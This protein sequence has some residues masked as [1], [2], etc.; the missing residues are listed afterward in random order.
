MADDKRR[1]FVVSTVLD[2]VA[3][4][5][6][7]DQL[8]MQLASDADG[9]MRAFLD[10][11][12]TMVFQATVTGG[13]IKSSNVVSFDTA[14]TGQVVLTK[15]KAGALTLADIPA[16]VAV[17]SMSHS[18]VSAL[19]HQLLNIYGPLLSKDGEDAKLKGLVAELEAGLGKKLRLTGG[20]GGGKDSAGAGGDPGDAPLVGI[21]HPLDEFKLWGEVAFAKDATQALKKCANEVYRAFE[22][23]KQRF[24][25]LDELPDEDVLELV[26]T[27]SDC[28]DAAWHLPG[29]SGASGKAAFPQRRMEHL[30]KIIG[31]SLVGHVQHKLRRVSVWTDQFKAVEGLLRFGHRCLAKWEKSCTDLSSINWADGNKGVQS[32]KG[33]PFTDPAAGKARERLDEVFKMRETQAELAKLLTAE[34]ARSLTLSEVFGPFAGVDPLQ[35]SE[36][37]APLWDAACSDYDQKMRPIEERLSQKLREHFGARLLPSLAAAVKKQGDQQSA[38]MAQPHQVLRE[39]ARYAELLRRPTMA[40]ALAGERKQLGESLERF[41]ANIKTECDRR[42]KP[43]RWSRRWCGRCRPWSAWRWRWGCAARW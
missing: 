41:M 5:E 26:D 21:V 10:D 3:P 12:T 22:P 19:Y 18:P 6:Q 4:A 31:S 35:V 14:S 38:A 43:R 28:L 24:E 23:M 42:A 16:N 29:E 20:T 11:Q 27:V 30:M 34:E 1:E 13:A 15:L 37:T 33:S 36:F 2:A 25:A 8:F 9:A 32:W 7:R 39:V 17:S 40:R